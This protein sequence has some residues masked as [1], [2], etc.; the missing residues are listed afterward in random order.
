[1][2]IVP[3]ER[4]IQLTKEGDTLV[5]PPRKRD[6]DEL[7]LAPFGIGVHEKD[8]GYIGLEPTKTGTEYKLVCWVCRLCIPVPTSVTTYAQLRAFFQEALE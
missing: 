5:I 3:P 4:K 6:E 1:M 2:S 8:D 7:V